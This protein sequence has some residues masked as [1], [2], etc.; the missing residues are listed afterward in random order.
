MAAEQS[1]IEQYLPAE[2]NFQK[3]FTPTFRWLNLGKTDDEI[4]IRY[5]LDGKGIPHC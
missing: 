2:V 3:A 4:A 1:T 5:G